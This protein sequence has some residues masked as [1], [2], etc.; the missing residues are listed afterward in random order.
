M[1]YTIDQPIR[2]KATKV[3][4]TVAAIHHSRKPEAEVLMQ[5]TVLGDIREQWGTASEF[6]A[7]A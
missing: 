6:E 1:E 4:G 2:H 3:A 7:D 5:Y